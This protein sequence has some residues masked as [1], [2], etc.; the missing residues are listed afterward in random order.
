[1][2]KKIIISVF[3]IFIFLLLFL[4]F[5]QPIDSIYDITKGKEFSIKDENN[6]EI[7][8]LINN[9]K[10]TPI[11]LEQMNQKNIDI[12]LAIEDQSF[13]QHSGFNV[14]RIFKTIFSNL[15]NQKSEGASTITQQYIKNVYFSN[16]KTFSRKIKEL[17]YAIKLE[18]AVPKNQILEGYLNCIYFGNDIYGIADASKYY[19]NKDYTMLSIQEMT[20]LVAL[21]NA[22]TYYSEHIDQLEL[23]KNTLLKTL[24][25]HNIITSDE[26]E[27]AKAPIQFHYNKNIYNSNLLFYV[28]HV[29]KEYEKINIPNKFNQVI[30]IE[31]AYRPSMNEIN[32]KT[33][34]DYASI[35]VDKDGYILSLIGGKNYMTSNYNIVTK[36]K[37]DIGS[38]IKP[39]L[40][41]EALKCG[42]SIQKAYYSS[43]YSFI[44]HNE[45]VTIKNNNSKYPNRK[46]TMKEALAA[47]DNIYAIKMHQEMGFKTLA[48][49]L[50]KYKIIVDPLPSLALGSVGMSLYDLTRIYTQF[51]TEGKYYSLSTIKKVKVKNKLVYTK[52]PKYKI[53]GNNKYFK[54]I[55]ELMQYTFD[56]TIPNATAATLYPY[57]KEKCYG[58]SGSTLYDSYMIGFNDKVLVAAWSGY[59]DNQ[60]LNEIEVKQLARKVF[61]NQINFA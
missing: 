15:K 6:Q 12:L 51:F 48:N 5:F 13:Y 49:H 45:Q 4:F 2:K 40:Y 60:E 34:G 16:K 47:S 46:I 35:S 26:F 55:K 42:F 22:P 23:R 59:I 50:K 32:L 52:K 1:M 10:T 31:T 18:Q 30:E 20:T 44:Y 39:L 17:Y 38:T 43:P 33:S 25:K 3:S 61:V 54:Q 9:H 53:L 8:H 21:L 28:D 36:G 7:L 11:Q 57:L 29:L 58:K 56:P 37:R 24:F 19:F 27:I 14:G 41:Y